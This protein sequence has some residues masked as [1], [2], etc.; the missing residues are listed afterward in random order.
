MNKYTL[1]AA[2]HSIK[3]D[4]HVGLLFLLPVP[5]RWRKR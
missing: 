5:V 1:L 2:W 4:L 3:K